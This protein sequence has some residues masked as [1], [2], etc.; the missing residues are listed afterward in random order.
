V[1]LAFLF[2]KIA[3]CKTEPVYNKYFSASKIF[4]WARAIDAF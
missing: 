2:L 1:E 3:C 4:Q